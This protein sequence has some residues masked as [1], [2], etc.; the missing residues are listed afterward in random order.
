[1]ANP[2]V[3]LPFSALA[4][5]VLK[6]QWGG[7]LYSLGGASARLGV[8][9][10]IPLLTLSLVADRVIPA[11]EEVTQASKCIALYAMGARLRPIRAI[12]AAILISTSAAV[13]EELAFRGI[14]QTLLVGALA[15]VAALPASAPVA[16]AVSVQ[17]A[18]FG[19]LH[20]YSSKYEYLLTASVAGLAFGAAFAASSNI[21]V[22]MVMHFI[23]DVVGFC[24]CHYQVATSSEAEQRSL[25]LSDAPIAKQLRLL[26][27]QRLEDRRREE[28]GQGQ[29]AAA[30]EG[31][32]A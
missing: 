27:G 2:L 31:G 6:L 14:L 12:L 30:A 13:A 28:Q 21:F 29:G 19:A 4:A 10:A 23:V 15:K 7:A 17:A 3:L 9:L 20:S 32:S 25:M 5:F 24:V 22:P 11:L 8:L 18:V 26:L 1:M 16:I